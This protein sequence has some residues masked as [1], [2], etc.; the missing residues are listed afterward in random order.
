MAN[1]QRAVEEIGQRGAGR[2]G[3]HD[4]EP[5]QWRVKLPIKSNSVGAVASA[6]LA[7]DCIDFLAAVS[8]GLAWT[9]RNELAIQHGYAEGGGAIFRARNVDLRVAHQEADRRCSTRI[10]SADV[11]LSAPVS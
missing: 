8:L 9:N 1:A 4:H 7:G 5:E 3:G 10:G 6:I 11:L 2:G